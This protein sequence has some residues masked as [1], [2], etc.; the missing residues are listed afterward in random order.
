MGSDWKNVRPA[1]AGRQ[2]S[3]YLPAPVCRKDEDHAAP[4][5]SPFEALDQVERLANLIQGAAVPA[6]R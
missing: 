3:L 5:V 2:R 4:F 6:I 1:W